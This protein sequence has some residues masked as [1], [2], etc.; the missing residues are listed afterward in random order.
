MLS[1]LP[2]PLLLLHHTDMAVSS[3]PRNSDHLRLPRK[4]ST[5]DRDPT[6]DRLRS[7]PAPVPAH[8]HNLNDRRVVPVVY[9]LSRNGHLEHPHFMEVTLSSPQGLYLRDCISILNFCRG[10]FVTNLARF[11][12]FSGAIGT[13]SC[14]M[15]WRRV[16]LSI[17]RRET[18]MFSKGRSFWS[19]RR[20]LH[21]RLLR[22]NRSWSRRLLLRSDL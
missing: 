16:I 18:S 6:P 11:L 19:L 8:P 21:R 22:G 5:D 14:G 17:R 13:V 1:L 15:I 4:W 9:Y 2:L 20:R 7:A 12:S 3:R 10:F